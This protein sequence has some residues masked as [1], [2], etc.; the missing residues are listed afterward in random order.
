MLSINWSDVENVL[1]LLRPYL[2]A[3]AMGLTIYGCR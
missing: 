2:I 1:E 3:I